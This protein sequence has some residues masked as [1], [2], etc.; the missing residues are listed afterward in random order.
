MKYFYRNIL[1]ILLSLIILLS[2]CRKPV[3]QRLMGKW[4]KVSVD[5]VESTIKETWDFREENLLVIH[6]DMDPGNLQ[7][8]VNASCRY[9]VN[10]RLRRDYIYTETP[11]EVKT[12]DG[13][14]EI[15]YLKKKTMMIVKRPDYETF[16]NYGHRERNHDRQGTISFKEFT[17]VE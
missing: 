14:W 5:K 6:K 15:V 7:T 1:F 4:E 9:M 17:R 3:E 12:Y 10:S 8:E 16:F 11:N 2:S 13:V